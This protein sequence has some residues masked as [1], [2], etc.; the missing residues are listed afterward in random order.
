MKKKDFKEVSVAQAMIEAAQK[1]ISKGNTVV[2]QTREKQR[3]VLKRKFLS[4]PSKPKSKKSW[5]LMLKT[6]NF[7]LQIYWALLHLCC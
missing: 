2:Q 4:Q 7:D 3:S 6:W 5:M 1:K